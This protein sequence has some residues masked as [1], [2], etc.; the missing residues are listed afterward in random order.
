M[1]TFRVFIPGFGNIYVRAMFQDEALTAARRYLRDNGISVE[2]GTESQQ[3]V[4]PSGEGS[5]P[6]DALFLNS[7]GEV[8]SGNPVIPVDPVDSTGGSSTPGENPTAPTTGGGSS[9]SGGSGNPTPPATGTPSTPTPT[10]SSIPTLQEREVADPGAAFRSFSQSFG[11]PT[12]GVVGNILGGAADPA[13]L[14]R[15]G[16]LTGAAQASSP[17]GLQDFS[18]TGLLNQN[19]PGQGV[20]RGLG[21]ASIDILRQLGGAGDAAAAELFRAPTSF[22]SNEARAVRDA[23]LAGVTGRN[24]FFGSQFG[25]ALDNELGRRFGD[26]VF[27]GNQP[28]NFINFALS[29]FGL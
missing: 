15:L 11:L 24:A 9:G 18:L 5:R 12:T 4:T 23:A 29:E 25:S 7:S 10:A 26:R 28:S 3:T 21:N 6:P 14:A 8:L 20:T 27:A 19:I 13:L 17:E 1:Q 16:S 22:G 2:Q